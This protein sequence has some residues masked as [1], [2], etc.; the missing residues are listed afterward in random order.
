MDYFAF[1]AKQGQRIPVSIVIPQIKGQEK[2]APMLAVIG[3]GLPLITRT[4][5][6]TS[7]INK[8]DGALVIAPPAK[9]GTFYE[10]FGGEYYWTQQDAV[11][12]API[13]GKFLIVVWDVAGCMGRYTLSVGSKEIR[14]GD[15]NYR[16][17]KKAYWTA[18]S[19]TVA[20]CR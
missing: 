6:I 11:F 18:I 4:L 9:A 1:S 15:S 20:A 2:F 7:A 10:P 8:I 19:N 13:D 17:K 3:P 5:P 14:G 16:N 12:K